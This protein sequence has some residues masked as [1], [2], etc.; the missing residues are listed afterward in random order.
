M[1]YGLIGEVLGHSYSKQIHELMT[2]YI[3]EPHPLK[4]DELDG[5]MKEKNFLGINVTIPYKQAVIP[6]LDDLDN[7]AKMVGAVNTILN[8]N[9]KLTGFNTDMPGFMY[10]LNSN[11]IN[12]DKKKVVVLGNGGASKA[13]QAAIVSMQK[14]DNSKLL[15][16]G[17]NTISEGMITY[18][19]L[20][21]QHTDADI[22]INTSPVGMYPNVDNSP[23]DLKNFKSCEAVV[24]IIANPLI[25]KLLSQAKSLGKKYCGGLT[26]LVAQAK[27]A[28]E[29]FLDKKIEDSV[30]NNVTKIIAKTMEKDN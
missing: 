7:S 23:L 17:H 4:K 27:F 5:F 3:Y 2:D 30:I 21:K 16:V 9:G 8:Q 11:G 1:Q 19:T 20:F 14:N 22:I 12:P 10:L 15:I 13:V 24:D 25:T 26:M 28:A 18:D 29:I 6:Y